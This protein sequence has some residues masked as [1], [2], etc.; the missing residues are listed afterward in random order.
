MKRTAVGVWGCKACG[1]VTAG[2]AY[3][4]ATPA[5]VQVRSNT[6]RLREMQVM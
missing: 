4:V 5:A 2:G 3:V 6:R 1:K